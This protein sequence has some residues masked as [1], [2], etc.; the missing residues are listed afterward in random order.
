MM[1]GHPSLV[2]TQLVD[3]LHQLGKFAERLGRSVLRLWR[4]VQHYA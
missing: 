4:D 1:F 3:C 2:K